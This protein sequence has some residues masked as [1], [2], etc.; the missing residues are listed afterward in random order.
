M[1]ETNDRPKLVVLSLGLSLVDMG[2][3]RTCTYESL[4]KVSEQ[5][6]GY[7]VLLE[8]GVRNIVEKPL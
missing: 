2:T 3:A 1:A 7:D 8:L 5:N 6:P 4:L